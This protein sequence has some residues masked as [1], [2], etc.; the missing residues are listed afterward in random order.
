MAFAIIIP[1]IFL[2]RRLVY[3]QLSIF[4]IVYT[5]IYTLSIFPV[6]YSLLCVISYLRMLF[7]PGCTSS[8]R[9]AKC[10]W[11][12]RHI[13]SLY[14][15]WDSLQGKLSLKIINSTNSDWSSSFSHK[16][17]VIVWPIISRRRNFSSVKT[18]V[19]VFLPLVALQLAKMNES[20]FLAKLAAF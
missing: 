8:N 16:W 11:K 19:S 14:T 6:T 18:I 13:R 7:T 20:E 17:E 15:C 4:S 12:I 9:N 3:F 5:N 10:V 2:M 1:Y